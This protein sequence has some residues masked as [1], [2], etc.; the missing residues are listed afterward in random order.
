MTWQ[1]KNYIWRPD[2]NL[3][4]TGTEFFKPHKTETNWTPSL[5]G[6]TPCNLTEVYC[7]FRG[8]RLTETVVAPCT[9]HYTA[10]YPPK[11]AVHNSELHRHY[12]I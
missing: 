2:I 4:D 8:T 3:R 11:S 5:Q 12:F 10:L 9:A 7:R 1:K 6:V